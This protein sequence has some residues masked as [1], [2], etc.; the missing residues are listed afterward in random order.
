MLAEAGWSREAAEVGEPREKL[1]GAHI[2]VKETNIK[3]HLEYCPRQD[4]KNKQ[5]PGGR[6]F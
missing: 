1:R 3:P 6:P 4:H 2:A 5:Q